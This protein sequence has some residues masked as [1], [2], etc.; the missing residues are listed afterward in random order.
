MVIVGLMQSAMSRAQRSEENS[1][2]HRRRRW[3]EYIYKAAT[4]DMP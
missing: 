4:I 1:R 3:L 2:D